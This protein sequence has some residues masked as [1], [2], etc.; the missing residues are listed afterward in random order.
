MNFYDHN[1][2]ILVQ[3]GQAVNSVTC[4][5]LSVSTGQNAG[6]LFTITKPHSAPS[7][8]DRLVGGEKRRINLLPAVRCIVWIHRTMPSHKVIMQLVKKAAPK[9][10]SETAATLHMARG[11]K[12]GST[13]I[14]LIPHPCH[15]WPRS[16]Q[17]GRS[18][19]EVHNGRHINNQANPEVP[20]VRDRGAEKAGQAVAYLPGLTLPLRPRR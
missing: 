6:P 12:P 9:G 4:L 20:Q 18:C 13:G 2:K 15:S 14:F 19:D 8:V 16:L 11:E 3:A 17:N 10:Y 5:A 1:S 7:V